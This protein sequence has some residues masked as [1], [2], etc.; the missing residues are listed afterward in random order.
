MKGREVKEKGFSALGAI[1]LAA[2]VGSTPRRPAILRIGRTKGT[3]H[4]ERHQSQGVVI[5]SQE[6]SGP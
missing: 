4:M 2:V 1:W 3:G 6:S 5:K